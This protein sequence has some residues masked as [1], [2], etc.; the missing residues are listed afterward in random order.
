MD[1]TAVRSREIA[2]IGYD[3]NTRVLE[4][5]FRRGGVYRFKN[6]PADMHH[7]LIHAESIGT[8][9]SGEIKGRYDYEKIS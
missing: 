7:K 8:F 3:E 2:L 6:V 9:F 4:V 5:T 1:R